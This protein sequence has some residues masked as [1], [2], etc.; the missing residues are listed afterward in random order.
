MG[1]PNRI[2]SKL[3]CYDCQHGLKAYFFKHRSAFLLSYRAGTINEIPSLDIVLLFTVS[4]VKE[5]ENV[6]FFHFHLHRE[7][8]P[9]SLCL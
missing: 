1:L 5:S 6:V 8:E 2:K 9:V 7:A 4:A 3:L